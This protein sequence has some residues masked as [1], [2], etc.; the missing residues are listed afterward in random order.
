M[1]FVLGNWN[2]GTETLLINAVFQGGFVGTV[3]FVCIQTMAYSIEYAMIQ[4]HYV[5][6]K[7]IGASVDNPVFLD[8]FF[9]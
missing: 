1:G 3:F 5:V 2:R 4:T 9:S 8:F 6:T 7:F